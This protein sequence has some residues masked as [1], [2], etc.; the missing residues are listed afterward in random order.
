MFKIYIHFTNEEKI[1][2]KFLFF[3]KKIY[4]S[5]IIHYQT[6]SKWLSF[7]TRAYN[8]SK[9]KN[10]NRLLLKLRQRRN[11]TVRALTSQLKVTS[12][13]IT[14]LEKKKRN[15]SIFFVWDLCQYYDRDIT[16]IYKEIFNH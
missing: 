14:K 6:I 9:D 13:Y 11:L 16:K 3:L 8:I 2:P 4:D 7:G 12:S 15:P 10:F 5:D 1:L